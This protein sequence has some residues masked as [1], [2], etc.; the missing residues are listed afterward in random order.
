MQVHNAPDGCFP[1]LAAMADQRAF[2]PL[3]PLIG[4]MVEVLHDEL[5]LLEIKILIEDALLMLSSEYWHFF[6]ASSYWR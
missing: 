2:E 5:V 3:L 4:H 1:L 6:A